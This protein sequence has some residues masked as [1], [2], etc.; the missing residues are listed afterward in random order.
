MK[1]EQG[2]LDSQIDSL[3]ISTRVKKCL[4]SVSIETQKSFLKDDAILLKQ[5]VRLDTKDTLRIIEAFAAKEIKNPTAYI[6]KAVRTAFKDYFSK[7]DV[8]SRVGEAIECFPPA[9]YLIF[10]VDTIYQL[11]RI[12]EKEALKFLSMIERQVRFPTSFRS[13]EELR[14]FMYDYLRAQRYGD[15]LPKIPPQYAYDDDE[16]LQHVP[17]KRKY[18]APPPYPKKDDEA[19]LQETKE[20]RERDSLDLDMIAA[21]LETERARNMRR[22]NHIIWRVRV[23]YEE[24][25]LSFLASG[26]LAYRPSVLPSMPEDIRLEYVISVSEMESQLPT[27]PCVWILFPNEETLEKESFYKVQRRLEAT[28]SVAVA[29]YELLGR[30]FTLFVV[31]FSSRIEHLLAK[32]NECSLSRGDMLVF[33]CWSADSSTQEK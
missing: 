12:S 2:D 5:I 21:E 1:E 24:L 7:W 27:Y 20:L 10:D 22:I 16:P 30:C 31:C 4:K 26:R 25:A 3:D 23:S 8:S 6:L 18:N 29:K 28:Q 19:I 14:T 13:L 9:G 33:V 11:S 15:P 17:H 32:H